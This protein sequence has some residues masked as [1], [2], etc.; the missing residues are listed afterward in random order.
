MTDIEE[1]LLEIDNLSYINLNFM[2]M[3]LKLSE[4]EHDVDLLPLFKIVVNNQKQ[5]REDLDTLYN[6]IVN[7][8]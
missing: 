1:I 7:K 8:A 4:L 5:M 3:G 2:K 6:F